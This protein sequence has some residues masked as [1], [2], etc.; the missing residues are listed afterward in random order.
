[1]ILQIALTVAAMLAAFATSYLVTGEAGTMAYIAFGIAGFAA[2]KLSLLNHVPVGHGVNGT[3][4]FAG[5]PLIVFWFYFVVL[6]M[7]V[8]LGMTKDPTLLP[9][10]NA[11]FRAFALAGFYGWLAALIHWYASASHTTYYASEYHERMRLEMLGLPKDE[12]D[13]VIEMG[14]RRGI[15][16]PKPPA[17]EDKKP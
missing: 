4:H 2:A 12:I 5:M 15:Y 14:R 17:V 3:R 9:A 1:M 7:V 10:T 11:N 6:L 13:Q 16:A 8:I